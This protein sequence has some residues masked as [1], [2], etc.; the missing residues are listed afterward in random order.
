[1]IS[2]KPKSREQS[3]VKGRVRTALPTGSDRYRRRSR[4]H[5]TCRSRDPRRRCRRVTK[6]S[7]RRS[8]I[9]RAAAEHGMKRE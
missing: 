1:M 5:C 8:Y 9:A 3:L 6:I 2:W 4:E 7:R